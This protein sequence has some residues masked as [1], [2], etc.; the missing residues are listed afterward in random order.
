MGQIGNNV[1]APTGNAQTKFFEQAV[2]QTIGGT[3]TAGA[4]AAADITT[5]LTAMATDLLAQMNAHPAIDQ[6]QGF[7]TG[8]P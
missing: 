7:A 3:G 1:S 8:Q 4:I 5:L 6:M 2:L